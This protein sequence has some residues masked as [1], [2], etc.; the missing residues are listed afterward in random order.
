MKVALYARVSTK[1]KD[2]NPETQLVPLREHAR[3]QG[4]EVYSEYVDYA[5]ALDLRGRKAWR[6]MVNLSG[7]KFNKIAV[8]RLDR[9]FRSVKDMHDYLGVFESRDVEFLSV[10]ESFDTSTAA[11]RLL[12]NLL[13]SLAEFELT[14]IRERVNDG[15]ERAR[16]QGK[17][18]GRPKGSTDKK[19]RKKTGYKMRHLREAVAKGK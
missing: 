2:Q 7:A 8:L 3:L 17:T 12:M 13:A 1:D 14:L 11:G 19:P 10:R 9:A 6:D 4:W 15:L 16:A 18:L 5:K